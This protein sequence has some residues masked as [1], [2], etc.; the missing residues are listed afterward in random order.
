MD[1]FNE[2]DLVDGFKSNPVPVMEMITFPATLR[3]GQ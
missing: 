2:M 1:L 3:Q